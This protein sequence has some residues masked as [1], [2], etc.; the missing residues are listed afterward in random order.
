MHVRSNLALLQ[1]H[2]KQRH[3]ASETMLVEYIVTLDL[4]LDSAFLFMG[5]ENLLLLPGVK[6][7]RLNLFI[8]NLVFIVVHL[9]L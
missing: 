2:L 7:Q 3:G 8:F 4:L 5:H 6:R 9:L 1:I